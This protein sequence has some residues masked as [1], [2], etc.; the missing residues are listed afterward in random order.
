MTLLGL[1]IIRNESDTTIMINQSRYIERML[2][3][4]NMMNSHTAQTPL[5]ASLPFLKAQTNDKHADQHL[6]QEII[7]SLNHI[8]VYSRPNIA[9]TV[10]K[11]SQFLNDPSETHMMAARH[12]LC[13]LKYMIHHCIISGRSQNLNILGFADA[14]WGSDVN[15]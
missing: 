9:F 14:D 12:V 10:S 6:Y 8:A 3:Q 5:N 15:D 2:S 13:Y 7:G 11:L 4:F 1:N